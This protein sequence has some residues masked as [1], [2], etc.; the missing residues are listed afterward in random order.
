VSIFPENYK[1]KY[2][3]FGDGARNPA[4]L[5]KKISISDGGWGGI[6]ASDIKTWTPASV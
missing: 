4:V 1:F 5:R 3:D 6:F 2:F